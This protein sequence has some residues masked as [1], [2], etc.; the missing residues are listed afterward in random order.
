MIKCNNIFLKVLFVVVL[1]G[2]DM[3]VNFFEIYNLHTYRFGV[4]EVLV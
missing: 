1:N 3:S 4:V 2:I